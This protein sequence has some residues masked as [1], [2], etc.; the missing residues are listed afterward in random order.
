M[1]DIFSSLY[2]ALSVEYY[3]KHFNSSD[4][5]TNYITERLLNESQFKINK[6]ID[7]L[8]NV[9][10]HLK[11]CKRNK[12]VSDQRKFLMKLWIIRIL[13]YEIKNI[14]VKDN[15]LE[16]LEKINTLSKSDPEY[17]ILKNKIINVGE[18]KN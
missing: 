17:D 18:F 5:L 16:D 14:I 8:G 6:V 11:R 2:L 7:N 12:L 1:A 9:S 13:F 10:N 3:H 15:I 4:I